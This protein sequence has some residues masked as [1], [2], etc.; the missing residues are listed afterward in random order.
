MHNIPSTPGARTRLWEIK[1]VKR[2]KFMRKLLITL[3]LCISCKEVL[4][5]K[6]G[7]YEARGRDGIPRYIKFYNDKGKI[8]G[9]SISFKSSG[10]IHSY[11][12]LVRDHQVGPSMI[13][14]ENGT[15]NILDT[16]LDGKQ[17]GVSVHYSPQGVLTRK[18]YYRNG[19]LDGEQYYFDYDTGDTLR[20]E[21]Y[22]KGNLIRIDSLR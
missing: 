18:T 9:Q 10:K 20:I 15:I 2:T 13:Y 17:E 14:Y 22:R 16:Y 6:E 1:T 8:E 11:I 12:Y 5:K 7:Y 4:N 19:V 3:L 21:H